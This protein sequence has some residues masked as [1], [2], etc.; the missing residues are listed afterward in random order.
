MFDSPE[1]ERQLDAFAYEAMQRRD[2]V[3]NAGLENIARANMVT[4]D[5]NANVVDLQAYR[6]SKQHNVAQLATSETVNG[7]ERLSA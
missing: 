2:S 5:A 3:I 1:K 6:A 7:R 4:I